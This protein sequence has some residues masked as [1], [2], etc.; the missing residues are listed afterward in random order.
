MRERRGGER[1]GERGEGRLMVEVE[2]K[3]KQRLVSMHWQAQIRLPYC[4]TGHDQAQAREFRNAAFL[5]SY[6][7]AR[8]G[9]VL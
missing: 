7:R 3:N 8:T 4:V 5:S 9:S 1:G 2:R 6:S